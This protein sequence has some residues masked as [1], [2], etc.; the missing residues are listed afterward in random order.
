MK[1]VT[2]KNIVKK[3]TLVSGQL[4]IMCHNYL[5]V[6]YETFLKDVQASL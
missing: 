1:V 6:I 2:L 5:L 3:P 4:D